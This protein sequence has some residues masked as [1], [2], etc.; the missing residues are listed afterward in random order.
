[1]RELA[2][3]SFVTL[4][5]VMQSPTGPDEDPS[6]D[7]AA[8]GWGAPFWDGVMPHVYEQAMRKPYDLLFGRRT[9]EAFA[10]HWPSVPQTDPVAERLNGGHKYVATRSSAMDLPWGPASIITDIA[11]ELAALKSGDGPLIQVHGSAD[12]IQSLLALEL[13]DEFRLWTFPVV[14]GP[15][16]RLFEHGVSG[17]LRL[18]QSEALVNGVVM[19]VYRPV[20]RG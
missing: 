1:M 2:V 3:L 4:D 13:V 8:G 15:G 17:G 5:G 19:S 9:Y 18:L 7:F 16:K 6:Q 11:A 10:A 14:V 20:S 12:L